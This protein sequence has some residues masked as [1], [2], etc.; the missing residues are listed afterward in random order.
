M[1][2][3]YD[4]NGEVVIRNVL[5]VA[6]AEH[7]WCEQTGQYVLSDP[8]RAGFQNNLTISGLH[9]TSNDTSG[10]TEEENYC[11]SFSVTY[12]YWIRFTDMCTNM[13][14]MTPRP[15][16]LD[17]DP[18]YTRKTSVEPASPASIV[19]CDSGDNEEGNEILPV[20]VR[21]S[22]FGRLDTFARC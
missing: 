14:M 9:K 3:T 2:Y 22:E 10:C 4:A 6:D 13:V 18:P 16:G 17:D 1:T 20:W 7:C 21:C 5:E 8:T 19:T 11:P 15:V 12:Q